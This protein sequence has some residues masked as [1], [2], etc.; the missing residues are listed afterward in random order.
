[1]NYREK[2]DELVKVKLAQAEARR[3]HYGTEGMLDTD[4]KSEILPPDDFNWTPKSNHPCG[5]W[6][7]AKICGENYAELLNTHPV[8]IDP[9][10]SLAGGFMILVRKH[11]GGKYLDGHHW[12]PFFPVP[13]DLARLQAL[14]DIVSGIGAMQ[15]FCPDMKMG[16][17]EGWSGILARVRASMEAHQGDAEKMEFLTA[18][19]QV[20]LGHQNWI[21]RHA[22]AAAEMAKAETD[23]DRRANLERMARE[24][25]FLVNNPPRTFRE[26]CQWT[27]WYLLSAVMYNGSGAGCAIDDYLLPYYER[28]I[29]D[30]ILTD[31]EATYHIACL[32]LKDNQYYEIG[33]RWPDGRDRTNAITYLTVEAAHWLKIPNAIC[34]RVH[35][36]IDLGIV[37]L[38]TKYLCED[39]TG[40]PAFLGDRA[41][42]EGFVKNGFTMEQARTRI[43]TGCH[44]TALQGT[45]YT[46]ND[47]VKI[48]MARIFEVAYQEMMLD[49]VEPSVVSLWERFVRHLTTCVDATARGID[50]HMA[51]IHKVFPELVLDLLCYGPIERGLDAPNGG[52]DYYNLCI[53]GAGLGVVADSF[54]ALQERVE[55]QKR[56][57]WYELD[58]LL[59]TNFEGAEDKRLMLN[60]A[61][62]YGQGGSAADDYAVR[63][64]QEFCRAVK[65]GPTPNG[66]NLIPGLFSWAN[67]IPMGKAVGAT[68]NGRKAGTPITHG[69][70]PAPGFKQSGA[71]T[72]VA[73]AVASVQCN[74]GNAVPIQ[75]EID[76]AMGNSEETI[77]KLASFLT[78][79]CTDM[80]GT[81]VNINVL[82]R[83]R[84]LEAHKNPEA[85]PDLVVRVTGFSAYFASLSKDFRQLVVD[86]IIEA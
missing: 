23:P 8:Y 10:S 45:E 80:G 76:P 34:L 1:M 56:V 44:W 30:G 62:R 58:R 29:A 19:E 27:A 71:L 52:V 60:T 37:R 22:K 18:L 7:G 2:V 13:E 73:N 83:E 69:A 33:G 55:D 46:M 36:D 86:R 11:R 28:D 40:S 9:N 17:R 72:A 26:A 31:E 3:E 65:R 39:K 41:M 43:K 70:N 53:D 47:T 78:T 12:P 25:E 24:N 79:Y 77:D 32:L 74:W 16:L 48:N 14:Y 38:A 82:N 66:Y 35:E 4:D 49:P 6:Y 42:N 54:A 5:G 67:T 84:I 75:L 59:R 81:L 51:H 64:T 68:P 85:H 57:T 15:H 50:F 63:I 61:S 20:V 21:A